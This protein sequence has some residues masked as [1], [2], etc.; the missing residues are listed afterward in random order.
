MRS[1]RRRELLATSAFI[2]LGGSFARAGIL[3][4]S[5]PWTPGAGTPPQPVYPGPW[6]FFTTSEG[7]AIEAIVDR[8]IP[9]DSETP[10]GKDSG[11]ATFI[12]R[13]LAGPY[14]RSEGLYMR[15]PFV[16]GLKQQGPQSP[17]TPAIQ[18]RKALDGLDAHCKTAYGGRAFADLADPDK[19]KVLTGLE[20]G[21]ISL[22][23]LDSKTFFEVLLKNTREGFFGDPIYGG[24]RDMA[25]WK[26]IG[27]P[28]TRYDYSD[29]IE[30]H[31]ERYPRPPV[32]IAG[33]PA[34]TVR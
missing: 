7:R 26:M 1:I 10:G 31:N 14:G 6:H 4:G 8:L 18:Y 24:N 25:G 19:D 2:L 21:D 16:K 5:L 3:Q 34:W 13:Q 32:S 20:H 9:P 33:S 23:G 27:F 30:R 28:G 15:G 29:W 11:C 12:D 17:L 22:P